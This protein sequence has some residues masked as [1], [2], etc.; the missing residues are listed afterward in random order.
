MSQGSITENNRKMIN[1]SEKHAKDSLKNTYDTTKDMSKAGIAAIAALA[2]LLT[3]LAM[4]GIK[5]IFNRFGNRNRQK[6]SDGI[7][8]KLTDRLLKNKSKSITQRFGNKARGLFR[9]GK[10]KSL[11]RLN[12]VGKTANAV[13]RFAKTAKV[14]KTASKTVRMAKTANTA[15]KA[16]KVAKLANV[17]RIGLQGGV[18]LAGG[19]VGVGLLVGSIVAPIAIEAV[20]KNREKIYAGGKK[21]VNKS[22]LSV[23]E[24]S[25][26]VDAKRAKVGEVAPRAQSLK[27]MGDNKQVLLETDAKGK[28]L[29][30]NFSPDHKLAFYQEKEGENTM[31]L[32]EADLDRSQQSA[33]EGRLDDRVGI[34][35]QNSQSGTNVIQGSLAQL[36]QNNPDDLETQKLANS[37]GKALSAAEANLNPLNQQPGKTANPQAE[38]KKEGQAASEQPGSPNTA[39]PQ[40]TAGGSTQ[41]PPSPPDSM[42]SQYLPQQ[43][44]VPALVGN[45]KEKSNDIER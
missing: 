39:V 18:A 41:L 11:G 31:L 1:A 20:W 40:Q 8:D 27:V 29:A 23:Q 9:G 19:P 17:A 6:N 15:Y 5:N 43:D 16:V 12:Q 35:N 13:N 22:K 37:L 24:I 32:D 21:V 3:R 4:E 2:Q 30:N 44:K 45:S 10:T 26:L 34:D 33:E 38:P 25:G 36:K 7:V 42:F 14:A 28:V